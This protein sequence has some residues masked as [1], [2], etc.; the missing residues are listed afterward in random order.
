MPWFDD[1]KIWTQD[2]YMACLAI[3]NLPHYSSGVSAVRPAIGSHT[4]LN[5][6]TLAPP[7]L[8]AHP[9]RD[10][11]RANLYSPDYK[12]T[13]E[14]FDSRL[15]RVL[16]VDLYTLLDK[17]VQ[18]RAKAANA[19]STDSGLEANISTGGLKWGPYPWAYARSI[20]LAAVRNCIIHN[21]LVWQIG[22][23]HRLEKIRDMGHYPYPMPNVGDKIDITMAHLFV[24]KSAVRQLLNT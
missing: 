20:E 13:R 6:S 8:R 22:Q 12:R 7:S 9:N 15:S 19:K 5:A 23:I 18:A 14:R 21:D 1:L 3:N 4:K 24:Y 11:V 10:V 2:L 17:E 16:L